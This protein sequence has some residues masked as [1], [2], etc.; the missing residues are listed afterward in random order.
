MLA[1]GAG[2]RIQARRV[3]AA[4]VWGARG[5]PLVRHHGVPRGEQAQGEGQ[6]QGQDGTSGHCRCRHHRDDDEALL[7][8]EDQPFPAHH[9]EA[10]RRLSRP[11]FALPHGRVWG[12]VG[13]HRV[14]GDGRARRAGVQ[15]GGRASGRVQLGHS[16]AEALPRAQ[17]HA[18]LLPHQAREV[19]ARPGRHGWWQQ[20]RRR[21]LFR[22][23]CPLRFPC[24]SCRASPVGRRP[25]HRL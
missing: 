24:L 1:L 15:P 6:L 10:A 9:S 2:Q 14:A 16:R 23:Q 20:Q 13:P 5:P 25:S 8:G 12:H 3:D 19:H 11:S 21:G 22:R 4:A 7:S 18:A 17:R